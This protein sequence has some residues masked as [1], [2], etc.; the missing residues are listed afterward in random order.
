MVRYREFFQNPWQISGLMYQIELCL[1]LG[2]GEH[3]DGQIKRCMLDVT[4]TD[5]GIAERARYIERE[6]VTLNE[7]VRDSSMVWTMRLPMLASMIHLWA[8]IR[9]KSFP[10]RARYTNESHRCQQSE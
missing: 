10:V 9:G 2:N 4:I 5:K 7:H 8:T 1:Q 3:E 6:L